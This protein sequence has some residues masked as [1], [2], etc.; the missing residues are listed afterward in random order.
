MHITVIV[1]ES[2]TR[3]H[4]R[5]L[6]LVF[7]IPLRYTISKLCSCIARAQQ[8]RS[9]PSFEPIAVGVVHDLSLM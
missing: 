9:L 7:T 8:Q 2:E 3:L 5:E 6:A 1:C 4:E